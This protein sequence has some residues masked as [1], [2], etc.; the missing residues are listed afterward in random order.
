M[1]GDFKS[2][3][4]LFR[5][6]ILKKILLP[7][8]Q[9]KESPDY[10]R[11]S[12][13]IHVVSILGILFS[14]LDAWDSAKN[15][16]LDR[17]IVDALVLVGLIGLLILLRFPK[18]I[19]LASHFATIGMGLTLL[20]N[21]YVGDLN[22]YGNAWA[23]V[24]PALCFFLLGRS[25]G[26]WV[27]IS[28]FVLTLPGAFIP[29]FPF[30]MSTYSASFLDS[31]YSALALI[32]AI[33]YTLEYSREMAGLLLYEKQQALEKT[34]EE[35][36]AT[37]EKMRQMAYHDTLTQLPNRALLAEHLS[38]AIH[39]AERY[40]MN[41]AVLYIDFDH[42]KDI[43][44]SLGHDAGDEALLKMVERLNTTIRKSDILARHGG[45]EFIILI[46]RDGER[47]EAGE[48]AAKIV[49]AFQEPIVAGGSPHAL[50]ASIGIAIFPEHA[51][52]S[53]DLL[54]RS[55]KAMYE[56]KLAGKNR[57]TFYSGTAE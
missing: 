7:E 5:T 9:P 32:G 29:K 26:L 45:D 48:L 31:Y 19:V 50:T 8:L 4:A 16:Y 33:T 28:Y 22:Y 47:K 44:D 35:L 43:N 37:E 53:E 42:F 56:A 2:I 10:S 54:N 15:W 49:A 38:A 11:K 24:F 27:L 36:A 20:F 30:M 14:L 6:E 12:I 1:K 52:T 39:R 51:R 17:L 23:F 41:I 13:A 40:K 34:V 57:F 46:P 3:T 55:D 25:F 21:F 18:R